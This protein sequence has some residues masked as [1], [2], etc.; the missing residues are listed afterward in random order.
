MCLFIIKH[1]R[2][3]YAGE[4]KADR[5]ALRR[6]R[7]GGRSCRAGDEGQGHEEVEG[8]SEASLSCPC[9][10]ATPPQRQR[11]AR[12]WTAAG[13]MGRPR[14][15]RTDATTLGYGVLPMM[16]DCAIAQRDWT[17]SQSKVEHIEI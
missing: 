15:W 9:V 10:P 2:C 7:R 12:L 14:R 8:V 4:G 5:A 16:S 17:Q 1:V 3:V 6:R 11:A 13:T